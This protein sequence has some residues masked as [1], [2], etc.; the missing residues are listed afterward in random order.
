MRELTQEELSA[1][2]KIELDILLEIDYICRKEKIKYSLAAGTLLGAI[3]HKGFIPW[4]DDIDIMLRRKEYDKLRD[5]VKLYGKEL[6]WVDYY[7][8]E[9]YPYPFSKIMMKNTIF[10]EE[11]NK[12]ATAP[13][14]I[15][16][17]VFPVDETTQ[18]YKKRMAQYKKVTKWKQRLIIRENYYFG[19][20]GIKEWYRVIRK[21]LFNCFPKKLFI[22]T[23]EK[24]CK[25]YSGMDTLISLTG[26]VGTEKA[27]YPKEWF[28][29][30]IEL[31]FAG[32]N[33]MAIRKCKELL[34]QQYGNYMELPPKKEQVPHHYVCDFKI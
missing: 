18:N 13:D 1:V 23:I 30:D 3:R 12:Y 11:S 29:E 9:G 6:Y 21:I 17:D 4:D 2:K 14:G 20:T 10:R 7:T 31:E 8:Y 32:R 24:E 34:E 25:K 27:T 33:F 26:T 5:C 22:D 16:I 19:Q 15:F 28:D